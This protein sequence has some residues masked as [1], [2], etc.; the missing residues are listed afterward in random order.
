MSEH[1]E[2]HD[3]HG[4]TNYVRIWGILLVLLVI[5][6]LGPT[7]EIQILPSTTSTTTLLFPFK[8]KTTVAYPHCTTQIP[9]QTS[10]LH[11]NFSQVQ[12]SVS[13]TLT[14]TT[15]IHSFLLS[16]NSP[17]SSNYGILSTLEVMVESIP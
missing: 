10:T 6:V 14:Y 15:P 3:D 2:N 17:T 13:P 5:S 16:G 8:N 11:S 7:L 1:A 4:H 9:C 12:S